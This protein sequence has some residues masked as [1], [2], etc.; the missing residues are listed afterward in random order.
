MCNLT[1]KFWCQRCTKNGPRYLKWTSTW[2][3]FRICITCFR[4]KLTVEPGKL[5]PS[6][7]SPS[8]RPF[9]LTKIALSK[10]QGLHRD[11]IIGCN[12]FLRY[13]TSPHAQ[14]LSS[15]NDAAVL[16]HGFLCWNI[17]FPCAVNNGF[18][19]WICHIYMKMPKNALK[20]GIFSQNMHHVAANRGLQ[21]NL[22][23]Q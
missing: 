7:D 18:L 8:N 6:K 23:Q 17:A 4:Q 9:C 1:A 14:S 21:I 20:T 5:I 3:A 12:N 11:A 16:R 2:K 10:P 13:S 22:S 19:L 15:D